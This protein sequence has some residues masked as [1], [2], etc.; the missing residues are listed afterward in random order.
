MI[1]LLLIPMGKPGPLNRSEKKILETDTNACLAL[2]VNQFG[3]S[4]WNGQ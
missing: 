2:A 4:R 3:L 1:P